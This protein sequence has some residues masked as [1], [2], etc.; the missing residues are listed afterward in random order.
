MCFY[1]IVDLFAAQFRE[2]ITPRVAAPC[3]SWNLPEEFPDFVTKHDK[4][5]AQLEKVAM[6]TSSVAFLAKQRVK[7]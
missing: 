6:M 2:T 7:P 1:R 3:R 4:I 5:Q